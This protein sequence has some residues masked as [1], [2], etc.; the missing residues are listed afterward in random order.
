[1]IRWK[2]YLNLSKYVDKL[3]VGESMLKILS[4]GRMFFKKDFTNVI[5]VHVI[6]VCLVHVFLSLCLYDIS[7]T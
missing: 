6:L 4:F 1:M 3:H 2:L 7:N 5:L